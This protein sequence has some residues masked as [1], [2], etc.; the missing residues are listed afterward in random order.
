MALS[1]CTLN[2]SATSLI[3]Q[4][5][6]GSQVMSDVLPS[7]FGFYILPDIGY[8]V[9]QTS[10]DN[11]KFTLHENPVFSLAFVPFI[12]LNDSSGRARIFYQ[13]TAS[14][15]YTFDQAVKEGYIVEERDGSG[16]YIKFD[17]DGEPFASTTQRYTLFLTEEFTLLHE[18]V[19]IGT[20]LSINPMTFSYIG[21]NYSAAPLEHEVVVEKM[22]EANE[23]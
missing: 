3:N 8:Y 14:N 18:S 13:L 11:G 20:T 23:E 7:Q 10:I 15:D 19:G 6:L 22:S 4:T 2:L 17:V 5:A 9:D 1:N 12:D 16:Y 21:N